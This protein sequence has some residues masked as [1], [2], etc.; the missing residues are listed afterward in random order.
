MEAQHKF[1]MKSLRMDFEKLGRKESDASDH[2][3]D[4]SLDAI[5]E[6][7]K[8]DE[9]GTEGNMMEST[10][11]L[12]DRSKSAG[13]RPSM[14]QSRRSKAATNSANQQ[15]KANN[16]E[17]VEMEKLIKAKKNKKLSIPNR[18]Q[19]PSQ[20]GCCGKEAQCHMF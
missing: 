19:S 2:R 12:R 6:K 7:G 1:K 4:L 17:V 9:M 11:S 18:V 20:Q 3:Y 13:I 16:Q 10:R 15:S 5:S 8:Y 14:D